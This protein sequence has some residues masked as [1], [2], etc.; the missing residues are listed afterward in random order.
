MHNM[1][2]R[3]KTRKLLI[4]NVRYGSFAAYQRA[5]RTFR[6]T[7]TKLPRLA[8]VAASE[9]ELTSRVGGRLRVTVTYSPLWSRRLQQTS[10]SACTLWQKLAFAT[11]KGS[12]LAIK[13]PRVNLYSLAHS[14]FPTHS[15]HHHQHSVTLPKPRGSKPR[16]A[17]LA[18]TN[19]KVWVR[20]A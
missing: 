4:Q 20:P 12:S 18:I 7:T 16:Y 11:A 13:L 15:L 19:S 2:S 9:K 14:H 10:L 5:Y 17:R 3:R 1:H 6:H 8:I